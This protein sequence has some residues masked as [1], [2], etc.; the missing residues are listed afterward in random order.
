MYQPVDLQSLFVQ[1]QSRYP[2]SSLITELVQIHENRFIVR[3]LVQIGGTTL[4]TSMATGTTVE[5]AEDQARS[6]LFSLLGLLPTLGNPA[7]SGMGQATSLPETEMPSPV[8]PPHQPWST[9]PTHFTPPDATP[10]VSPPAASTSPSP[11][12]QVPQV[13]ALTPVPVVATPE[14]SPT[15]EPSL[16][17]EPPFVASSSRSDADISLPETA[18]PPPAEPFLPYP[19]LELEITPPDFPA[20]QPFPSGY[21]GLDDDTVAI[22]DE[23]PLEERVPEIEALPPLESVTKS[24]RPSKSGR[25]KTSKA[26]ANPPQATAPTDAP[27]DLAPLFLQIEQEMERIHW[28]KE[29]G[30][31]HLKQTYGKRSRQQLTDEELLDF[32]NYLK[33]RPLYEEV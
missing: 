20:S 16:S 31:D 7:A 30:R 25:S 10:V 24:E 32:L 14:R 28:T 18:P 11:L 22:D 26:A 13:T 19:D 9:F 17:L 29:Q 6:R 1:F 3:A 21:D 5:L 23:F 2:A 27:I 12:T 4:A 15:P 33:A 8:T